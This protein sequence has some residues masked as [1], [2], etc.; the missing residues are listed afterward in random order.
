MPRKQV[1]FHKKSEPMNINAKLFF[2]CWALSIAA[3]I[4]VFAIRLIDPNPNFV[5][6]AVKV[7]GLWFCILSYVFAIRFLKSIQN[8][9]E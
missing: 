6:F 4:I 5:V 1:Y 7:T 3:D 8:P 9:N 2:L